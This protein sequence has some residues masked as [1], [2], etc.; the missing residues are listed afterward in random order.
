[1]IR[2]TFH[3]SGIGL[4]FAGGQKRCRFTTCVAVSSD[5]SP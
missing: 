4:P 2:L 1:L 3:R 5:T